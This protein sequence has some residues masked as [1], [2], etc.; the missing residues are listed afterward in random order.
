M[1]AIVRRGK[2]M[3]GS[4]PLRLES[5][6]RGTIALLLYLTLLAGSAAADER[7][8]S[9]R[10]ARAQELVDVHH[11]DRRAGRLPCRLTMYGE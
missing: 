9:D 8:V 7:A 3:I 4:R 2:R 10:L 6:M 5:A 1:A 11:G